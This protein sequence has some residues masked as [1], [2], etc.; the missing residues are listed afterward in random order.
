MGV[1]SPTRGASEGAS[2]SYTYSYGSHPHRKRA[3][4]ATAS[5]AMSLLESARMILGGAW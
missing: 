1:S 3:E 5:A 4:G 2:E